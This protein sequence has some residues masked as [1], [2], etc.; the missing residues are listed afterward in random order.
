MGLIPFLYVW[1]LGMSWFGS[2]WFWSNF[3]WT[4]TRTSLQN[5]LMSWTRTELWVWFSCSSV[6]GLNQFRA[7]FG[8]S[9]CVKEHSIY[10]LLWSIWWIRSKKRAIFTPE[11]LMCMLMPLLKFLPFHC[12]FSLLLHIPPVQHIS[13]GDL[14]CT[15][16]L[17]QKTVS[18]IGVC[19][20]CTRK[21]PLT[22]DW[23]CRN[24]KNILCHHPEHRICG[25]LSCTTNN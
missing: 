18:I 21:H 4:R 13:L 17:W 16:V 9:S 19:V 23:W 22:R 6:C 2:V 25:A 15:K 7:L 3:L 8:C 14:D 1:G 24:G 5:D 20:L 11:S 12:L 10:Y